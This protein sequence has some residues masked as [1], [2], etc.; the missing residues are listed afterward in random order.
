MTVSTMA[1]PKPP[2]LPRLGKRLLHEFRLV[3]PPTIFFLVGFHLILFT[4][5]LILAHYMIEFTGFAVA[6]V[7]ALI[8]GKVVLVADKASFMR[9]FDHAPLAWPILFKATVYT[10]LVGAV[11][12]IEAFI[13]Y[14]SE[15]GTVGGGAYIA[16]QLAGFTSEQFL[17]TQIW[18][19]V[20]FL[21]YVT[22][23]G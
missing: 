11:R 3:L 10:L 6:T 14:L 2:L 9:R 19:F 1:L 5:R 23:S 12:A 16:H 7:S 18:I 22:A 4:K 20:L 17:A 15:G 13:D 21:I 8:V